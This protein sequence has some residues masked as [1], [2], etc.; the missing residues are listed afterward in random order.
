MALM[1]VTNVV[2]DSTPKPIQDNIN[3]EV[4]FEVLGDIPDTVEWKLTYIGAKK[5]N[6]GDQTL[7]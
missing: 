1:N 7:I 6:T 2:V 3:F 5:D 4:T